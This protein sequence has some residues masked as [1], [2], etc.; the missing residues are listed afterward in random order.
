MTLK[1]AGMHDIK[2]GSFVMGS[3][4]GQGGIDEHPQH[5]VTVEAFYMD[6]TEVTQDDYA[7]LMGFNPSIYRGDGRLPVE[8]VTW[9]DAVLYC[10]NRSKRDGLPAV[11]RFT[12]EKGKAGDGCEDLENLVIDY[13]TP[14]L[15]SAYRGGMGVCLPGRYDDQ[16][17]LG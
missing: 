11:Y 9:Y 10:N 15:P 6:I 1:L 14:G 3:P 16:A 12:G 2:G 4:E 7:A 17:F 13:S 8:N 5:Q